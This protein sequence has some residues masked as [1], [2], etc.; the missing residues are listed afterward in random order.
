MEGGEERGEGGGGRGMYLIRPFAAMFVLWVFPLGANAALEEVVVAFESELG[1]WC[2]VVL[3]VED[4][5]SGP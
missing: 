3:F 5:V 2:D 1:G 4:L